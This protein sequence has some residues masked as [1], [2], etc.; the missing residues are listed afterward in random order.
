MSYLAMSYSDLP[1]FDFVSLGKLEDLRKI[2]S[3][4]LE[5]GPLSDGCR[6]VCNNLLTV[7]RKNPL[8]VWYETLDSSET[9]SWPESFLYMVSHCVHKKAVGWNGSV[10]YGTVVLANT[11]AARLRG[12]IDDDIVIFVC[13]SLNV[14]PSLFS[15]VLSSVKSMLQ[16][17]TF[18]NPFDVFKKQANASL[19]ESVSDEDFFMAERYAKNM[20]TLWDGKHVSDAKTLLQNAL[21]RDNTSQEMLAALLAELGLVKNPTCLVEYEEIDEEFWELDEE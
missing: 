21:S 3:D 12:E 15:D 7:S 10:E 13:L 14:R 20:S 8:D 11:L 17:V 4:A 1:G 18:R 9:K 19:W 2:A 6:F 5:S 16:Y